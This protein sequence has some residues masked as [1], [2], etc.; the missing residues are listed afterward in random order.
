MST[1]APQMALF[2]F[3]FPT[4]APSILDSCVTVCFDLDF[5]SIFD[6]Q[7][8]IG[9]NMSSHEDATASEEDSD[10]PEVLDDARFRQGFDD[11]RK[12]GEMTDVT[13]TVGGKSFPAHKLILA[14]CSPYFR[15]MFRD[16][17]FGEANMKTIAIDP[18]GQLGIKATAVG[19]LIDYMYTGVLDLSF[20]NVVDIIWA[21]DLLQLPDVKDQ[22]LS[23]LEDRINFETYLDIGEVGN[24]FNR[25]KLVM[26]VNRFIRQS[27]DDFT[28][29]SAFLDLAFPDLMNYLSH[30]SLNTS[31]EY[32]ILKAAIRWC[33]HNDKFDLFPKLADCIN[34]E[35]VSVHD[36]CETLKDKADQITDP[37]V[38]SLILD[39]MQNISQP[40]TTSRPRFP[41]HTLI[42]MPYRSKTFFAITFH[43]GLG[44]IEFEA[45][46][47]PD[48]VNDH[49]NSL[50]NYNVCSFDN[51][52]YLAGGTNYINES[53]S[54]YSSHGFIYNILD[55]SWAMGPR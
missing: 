16:N 19:Q 28:E 12:S 14:A 23:S 3:D 1:I 15:G 32:V 50:T 27:F 24:V 55:N 43:G 6:R 4:S 30:K 45:R 53:E 51:L 49:I 20:K 48:M 40:L 52:V 31:S 25:Q 34:F 44:S 18:E 17:N 5:E 38:K 42:A 29:T 35:L 47:F 13:I 21:A 46:E 11:M 41:S 37:A 36:L 8:L 54:Q 22:A 10:S 33:R 2:H 9:I 39:R 26:A 7:N